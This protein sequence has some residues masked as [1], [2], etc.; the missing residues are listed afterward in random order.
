MSEITKLIN[1]RKVIRKRVTECAAKS[2][3]YPS[4]DSAGR[5]FEKGIL[6]GFQET[7]INLNNQIYE[8]KFAGKADADIEAEMDVCQDYTDKIRGCL[9][10]LN[11]S[12]SS[13]LT[14]NARSILR[15]PVAPLPKFL[16]VEG[17]DFL[18][19]ISE[20]EKTTSVYTYPDRDLLLL[21]KQQVEGRAKLLLGSLELDKQSYTNAKALLVSAFASAE[22][23]KCNVIKTLLDLRLK[24]NDDPYLFIS[25]L[26][27]VKES[28][29]VLKIDSYE[30]IRYFVWQALND[31]FKKHLVQ[32]TSKT[33]PSLKEILDNFFV[34]CNRYENYKINPVSKSLHNKQKSV[35]LAVKADSSNR[36]ICKL[37]K[38]AKV[39]SSHHIT[40]CKKFPSPTDK[41]NFIKSEKGCT[42]CANFN[43]ES[44]NCN[45]RFTRNCMQCKRRH[46]D[47]L[48]TFSLNKEKPKSESEKSSSNS[49]QVNSGVA[50]LSNTTNNSVLPTFSFC[51]EGNNQKFRGLRDSGSQSTFITSKLNKAYKFKVLNSNVQLTISGFNGPKSYVTNVV[52]VPLQV[53]CKVYY[54][55]ALVVPEINVNISL[56]FLGKVVEKMKAKGH[57]LADQLLSSNSNCIDNVNL[58]LGTDFFYCLP[59]NEITFGEPEA[60]F[61]INTHAGVLLAGNIETYLRN[62]SSLPSVSETVHKNQVLLEL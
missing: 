18:K 10:I 45:Y 51:V 33:T 40:Q 50:V 13:N 43:H 25:R 26:R 4:Y 6:L 30:F 52:E 16:G 28:V 34:A 53:G 22:V 24:E 5:D 32:I 31:E 12:I 58:L 1:E 17:E 8:L 23:R 62:L 60:S 27:T 59:G 36:M 38:K 39:D 44:S 11:S 3:D 57:N 47:N 41:V 19:F 42:R 37:C 20:F 56:P 35:S 2:K 9:Q 7:L 29:D 14:D 49:A 15:Q 55:A 54:I 21:L 48:C 46:F 61:Y